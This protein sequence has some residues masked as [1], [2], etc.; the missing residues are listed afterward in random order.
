MT[1]PKPCM[2]LQTADES[3]RS[4]ADGSWVAAEVHLCDWPDMHPDRLVNAPRWMQRLVG[5]GLAIN[6]AVDC[7]GCAA[8]KEAP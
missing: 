3:Y 6:P 2:H 1:C 4:Y 5:A 8:H 7:V